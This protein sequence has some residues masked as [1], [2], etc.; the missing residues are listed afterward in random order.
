VGFV[1]E[2]WH[3]HRLSSEYLGLSLSLSFH[4]RAVFISPSLT[5]LN[6]TID[7]VISSNDRHSVV[8]YEQQTGSSLQTV[9]YNYIYIIS[10]LAA[11]FGFCEKGS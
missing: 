5:L 9:S 7:S 11:C 10:V 6:A 3:W 8:I 1:V 2:K 4:Q